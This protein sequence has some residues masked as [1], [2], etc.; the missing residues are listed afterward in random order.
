MLIPTFLSSQAWSA[1]YYQ[2]HD[3]DI[4]VKLD[5]EGTDSEEETSKA[6]QVLPNINFEA[7][8]ASDKASNTRQLASEIN[9]EAT[10]F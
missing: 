1:C 2:Q 7:I 6:P 5:P 9:F 4:Q 10:V 3:R 8:A